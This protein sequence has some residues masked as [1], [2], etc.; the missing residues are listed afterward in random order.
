MHNTPTPRD[1]SRSAIAKA[2]AMQRKGQR[3]AKHSARLF[4]ALAFP[5]DLSAL[6]G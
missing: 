6:Q 2:R 5:A 4:L 1:R 3:A